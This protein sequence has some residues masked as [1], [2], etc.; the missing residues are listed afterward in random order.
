MWFRVPSITLQQHSDS[1]P[2]RLLANSHMSFLI[3]LFVWKEGRN[4]ARAE[5]GERDEKKW[6]DRGW[7][8][9]KLTASRMSF[10]SYRVP[11][12]VLSMHPSHAT[13]SDSIVSSTGRVGASKQ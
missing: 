10:A 1:P 9:P 2:S 5:V 11:T 4:G 8:D 7:W 12:L 6:E 13:E 3:C